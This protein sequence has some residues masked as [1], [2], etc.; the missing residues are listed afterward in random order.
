MY[1]DLG[2]DGAL[3][4]VEFS[5][6]EFIA[7]RWHY[8][9]GQHVAILAP[10][11]GGKTHLMMQLLSA[12]ATPEL[13]AVILEIK[14]RDATMRKFAKD[15]GYRI[16]R[17]WPPAPSIW[18]PRKPPG[19]IV[20]PQHTFDPDVDDWNL[21]RIHRHAIMH[22]YR[23]GHRIVAGDEAAGLVDI[24]LERQIK[25]I[26]QRGRSMGTGGWWA[27]QRPFEIPLSIYGMSEHLFLGN[28]PDKRSRDRYAE[29]GGIDPRIPQQ[30][31]ARLDKWHFLYIRRTGRVLCIVGP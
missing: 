16:V 7:E 14:P 25:A 12:T 15:N 3:E 9:P 31:T 5:R 17:Q 6:E 20:W 30:I 21:E 24:K 27:S 22:S 28:D 29:I 13:P 18:H 19:Y 8:K 26:Q 1:V 4:V 23:K 11:D 2:A 10:T